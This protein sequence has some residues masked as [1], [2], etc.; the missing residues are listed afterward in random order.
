MKFSII[1]PVY[2]VE[3]YLSEA[4]ESVI[5]QKHEDFELIIVNDGSTDNS[6]EIAKYYKEN[7]VR[8]EIVTQKNKG[9]SSARNTGLSFAKGEYIYFIDSDDW[10]DESTLSSIYELIQT[11][12]LD[13]ICFL[14]ETFITTYKSE[15]ENQKLIAHYNKYYQRGY[16]TEKEYNAEEYL[17]TVFK[18]DNFVASACLYVFKKNL[19]DKSNLRFV[20]G[21]IYEDNLFTIELISNAKNLFLIPKQFYK[22]RIRQDSITT[23]IVDFRKPHSYLIISEQL[24]N[25]WLRKKERKYLLR[26]SKLFFIQALN[27]IDKEFPDSQE[28]ISNL[29]RT[30]NQQ[31]SKDHSHKIPEMEYPK[32]KP[33][34]RIIRFINNQIVLLRKK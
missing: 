24:F 10:I 4:I 23:S 12:N 31:K 13:I 7:D 15:K 26:E 11:K 18:H 5:N 17:E 29:H 1:M 27:L 3:Q 32:L 28:L 21:I 8:I 6:L 16:L 14:A 9:L 30:Y 33:Y 19:V 22:R 20:E 34:I 2:N 25:L